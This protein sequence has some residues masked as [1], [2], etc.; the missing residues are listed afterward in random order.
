MQ[1]VLLRVLLRGQKRTTGH[2]YAKD[3]KITRKARKKTW[4]VDGRSRLHARQWL[5]RANSQ[6][7]LTLGNCL[8]AGDCRTGTFAL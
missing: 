1:L 7:S 5:C 3:A 8:Q 4:K 6:L 2:P